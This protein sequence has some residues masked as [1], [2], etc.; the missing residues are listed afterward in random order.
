MG[1]SDNPR[2]R[3]NSRTNRSQR[4]SL[5][6]SST[7][8]LRISIQSSTNETSHTLK[9]T[10]ND[11]TDS[12]PFTQPRTDLEV[13]SSLKP[14]RKQLMETSKQTPSTGDKDSIQADVGYLR[15]KIEDYAEKGM[16][17]NALLLCGKLIA[18]HPLSK[19]DIFLYAKLLC[20]D[21]Q[22]RR[23]V[24]YMNKNEMLVAR[25]VL[26]RTGKNRKKHEQS[27]DQETNT[28]EMQTFVR[29]AEKK[30]F[31]LAT[32]DTER[33]EIENE[34]NRLNVRNVSSFSSLSFD[35][36]E[37]TNIDIDL[38]D[39]VDCAPNQMLWKS[40]I[41]KEQHKPTSRLS[42]NSE[43]YAEPIPLIIPSSTSS[44]KLVSNI[45][46]AEREVGSVHQSVQNELQTCDL[47]EEFIP[48]SL[49]YITLA[50]HCLL[51]TLL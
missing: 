30:L 20:R 44:K 45:F 34:F 11:I 25:K 24:H 21:Q 49:P 50:V 35:M 16:V 5:K 15:S 13:S 46:R 31:H 12:L 51:G 1:T 26:S 33:D 18:L 27:V 38:E 29:E 9:R 40:H 2:R 7:S 47:A 3:S 23:A 4:Q 37:G 10:T 8:T 48:E 17:K 32:I 41:E 19:S 39:S 42:M 14:H 36:K 22:Y 28:D 43:K 6:R